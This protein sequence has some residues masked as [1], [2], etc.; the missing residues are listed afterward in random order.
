MNKN[1]IHKKIQLVYRL[2]FTLAFSLLLITV[3]LIGES[4]SVSLQ[5]FITPL[6][7]FLQQFQTTGNNFTNIFTLSL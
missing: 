4:S 7:A 2:G 6:E 3:L 5:T 1:K